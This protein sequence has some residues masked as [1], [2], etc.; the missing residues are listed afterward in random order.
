MH[1]K[2]MSAPLMEVAVLYGVGPRFAALGLITNM[3]GSA[4]LRGHQAQGPVALVSEPR[5]LGEVVEVGVTS[6]QVE[7]MLHDEGR[8]PDVIRGD[9]SAL[10]PELVEEPRV[11]MRG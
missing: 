7:L 6:E 5:D 11:V 1:E 3:A 2:V 10:M 9:R 4:P 8:D